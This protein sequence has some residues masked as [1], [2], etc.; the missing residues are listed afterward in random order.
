MSDLEE[1]L[2]K[3]V[4]KMTTMCTAVFG[5]HYTVCYK[6]VGGRGCDGWN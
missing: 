4:S 6:T 5:V 3:L 1:K 2:S